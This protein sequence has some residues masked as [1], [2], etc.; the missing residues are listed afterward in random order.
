ME[1]HS[2][3]LSN[4]CRVDCRALTY[5]LSISCAVLMRACG[6][7]TPCYLSHFFYVY[8]GRGHLAYHERWKPPPDLPQGS[9]LQ[10][11]SAPVRYVE[12]EFLPHQFVVV[13]GA[14]ERMY[15][16]NSV[17]HSVVY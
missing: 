6:K 5:I 15:P 2:L 7:Y 9:Q 3:A 1:I 14:C 16:V 13:I 10:R 4:M 17:M 11:E 12:R 8:P